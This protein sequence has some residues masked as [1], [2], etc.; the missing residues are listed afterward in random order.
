[1][2]ENANADAP[3]ELETLKRQAASMGIKF[4]PSISVDKLK[5]RIASHEAPTE[6]VAEP[7][8]EVKGTPVRKGRTYSPK[9][10]ADYRR[11][12]LGDKRRRA[13]QLVRVRVTC[14][15]PNKREWE[16]EIISVG[17][18]KLGTF[19]KYVPFNLDVG[20][21]IPRI[22]YEAMKERR[23]T[24]FKTVRQ[25]PRGDKIRKGHLVPEFAIEVL[26]ALTMDQLKDLREQQAMAG[27][28]DSK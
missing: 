10:E 11:T 13:N 4:H 19:K 16:G 1:M 23:C 7:A 6:A 26:P 24:V 17:S 14:M 15:N 20:Y 9:T 8:P 27:S 3:S 25:G 21:H 28:I 12:S 5:A 22:I 2:T 18:A